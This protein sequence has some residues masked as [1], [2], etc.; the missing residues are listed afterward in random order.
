[1]KRFAVLGVAAIAVVGFLAQPAL[2][3]LP[4]QRVRTQQARPSRPARTRPRST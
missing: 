3:Q 2:A 1:M 4:A